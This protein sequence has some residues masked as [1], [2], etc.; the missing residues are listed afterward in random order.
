MPWKE[1]FMTAAAAGV[2]FI[3]VAV[4]GEMIAKKVIN[5]TDAVNLDG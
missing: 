5:L 3:G 4:F 2:G 1:F